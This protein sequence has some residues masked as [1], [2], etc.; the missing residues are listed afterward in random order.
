MND[1]QIQMAELGM[2]AIKY[3]ERAVNSLTDDVQM[4]V[5]A[6][7]VAGGQ[8]E[9]RIRMVA[10]QAPRMGLVLIGLKGELE[11]E[12]YSMGGA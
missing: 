3:M 7:I 4:K 8:L 5:I 10:K 12:L 6:G 1:D 11:L 2:D 9:V